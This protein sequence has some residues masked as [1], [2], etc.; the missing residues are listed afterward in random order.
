MD[1]WT[2]YRQKWDEMAISA[3]L[4]IFSSFF[5][6]QLDAVPVQV[7]Y[8]A[9]LKALVVGN[10]YDPACS[11]TWS[12]HMRESLPDSVM[13]VWQGVGHCLSQGGDY[14]GSGMKPCL[15]L[16]ARYWRTGELP[17]DGFTCRVEKPV[18]L[19]NWNVETQ[20]TI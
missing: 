9:G 3:F 10:L 4:G 19:G 13:I 8:R 2:G 20:E 11:Y 16:L 15:D 14:P 5:A 1:I 7:G 18:P 12:N 6:W 17:V